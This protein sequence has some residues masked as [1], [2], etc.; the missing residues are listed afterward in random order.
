MMHLF[1]VVLM[2]ASQVEAGDVF[3]CFA[4]LLTYPP[5]L[6]EEARTSGSIY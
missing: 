6:P 1:F 5:M 2:N 3:S 4:P